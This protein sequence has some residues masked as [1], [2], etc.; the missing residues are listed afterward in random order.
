MFRSHMIHKFHASALY[1]EGM[2]PYKVNDL[3]KR[4]KQTNVA[5]FMTDDLKYE[6]IQYMPAVT[7][8]ADV[9]KLLSSHISSFKLKRKMKY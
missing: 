5:Y 7:I 9:E 8:N 4:Q 1:N 3:Q 6:Y 2:S